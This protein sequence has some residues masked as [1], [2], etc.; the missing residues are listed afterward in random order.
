MTSNETSLIYKVVDL[1]KIFE[2]LIKFISIRVHTKKLRFFENRLTL[3]AMGHDGCRRRFGS[4]APATAMAH[5]RFPLL[6][7]ATSV[8]G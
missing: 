1:V 7:W 4:V 5:G 3:T 8:V 2:F 6:S